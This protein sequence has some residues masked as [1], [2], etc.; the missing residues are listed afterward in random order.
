MATVR[1]IVERAF[2]KI[3]VV[4]SDEA[5]T[6]DQAEAGETALNMMMN[7]WELQ[8]VDV[9]HNDVTLAE[10][11]PLQPK[12]EEG[13]VYMLA[14]RLAPDYSKPGFDESQWMQQL[15]AA[16]LIVDTVRAPLALQRTSSQRWRR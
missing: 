6:A 8:G 1:D 9:A 4:A 7:A 11:F 16:Y 5:M 2:R 10:Q 13:A 15:Q 14:S 3:G 12:F